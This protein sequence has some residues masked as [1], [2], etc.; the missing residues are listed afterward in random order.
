MLGVVAHY[1]QRERKGEEDIST[2]PTIDNERERERKTRSFVR[3][4]ISM[5]VFTTVARTFSLHGRVTERG[6]IRLIEGEGEYVYV[7]ILECYYLST[8][9]NK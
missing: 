6:E 2:Q 1:D 8:W 3:T 7:A 9:T 5:Y 4:Y